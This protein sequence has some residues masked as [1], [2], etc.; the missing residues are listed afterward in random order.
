M[1]DIVSQHSTSVREQS[2][3][4]SSIEVIDG[5]APKHGVR[6]LVRLDARNNSNR[7]DHLMRLA[8]ANA[9]YSINDLE[10][11]LQAPYSVLVSMP[12][13]EFN[14]FLAGGALES[15]WPDSIEVRRKKMY[16]HGLSQDARV[17]PRC[18]A[19][20]Y[21]QPQ[22]FNSDI[23]I[24]CPIHKILPLDL[25]PGC[26]CSLDY[27]RRHIS[28]C[29]C[30]FNFGD[31]IGQSSPMWLQLLY[32]TFAPWHLAGFQSKPFREIAFNDYRAAKLIHNLF[33]KGQPVRRKRITSSDFAR[34]DSIFSNFGEEF[35]KAITLYAVEAS[36]AEA[37]FLRR[38]AAHSGLLEEFVKSA[39]I[40]LRSTRTATSNGQPGLRT[41]EVSAYN[42]RR[43]AKLDYEATCKLI[44]SVNPEYV[45]DY[46]ISERRFQVVDASALQKI[47]TYLDGTLSIVESA[48]YL[49]ISISKLRA[50][51][52]IGMVKAQKLEVKP[53]TPRFLKHCLDEWL[54]ILVRTSVRISVLNVGLVRLT[55]ISS[56]D[57][58]GVLRP[59]WVRLIFKI[60]SR[61]I[62]LS[63]LGCPSQ[64]SN[65]YVSLQDIRDCGFTRKLGMSTR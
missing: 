14:A 52:N 13:S 54:Q 28:R 30:G 57:G 16:R 31:A 2:S 32:A 9:L 26:G 47:D 37:A 4:S 61:Q 65:F 42:I 53:R 6:L 34:M 33:E 51:A 18:I 27:Q 1:K 48:T 39:Q 63:L 22:V 20:N 5:A 64:A 58:S 38:L 15:V 56:T 36:L 55:D 7:Q 49:G 23:P 50:L 3:Y 24:Q 40:T 8:E 29:N 11:I 46:E 10:L 25:C 60:E 62:V 35:T 19:E 44:S 21:P 41:N 59:T 43:K 17:C 12:P 45:R